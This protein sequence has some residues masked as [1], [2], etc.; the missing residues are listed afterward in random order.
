MKKIFIILNLFFLFLISA[1]T[2]NGTG[3]K[4]ITD[5]AGDQ[6][7]I[8]PSPE[9]VVARTANSTSFLVGMGLQ[10]RIVGTMGVC[11]MGEERW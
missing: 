3:V 1:C 4:E 11:L 7:E 8:V 5:L 6:V 9:R 2:L 10:D